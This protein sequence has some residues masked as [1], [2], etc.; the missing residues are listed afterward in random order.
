MVLYQRMLVRFLCVDIQSNSTTPGRVALACMFKE[1]GLRSP[2]TQLTKVQTEIS[3]RGWRTEASNL[4]AFNQEE[5]KRFPV[6]QIRG[7]CIIQSTGIAATHEPCVHVCTAKG[8]AIGIA[9][10]GSPWSCWYSCRLNDPAFDLDEQRLKSVHA[11][12]YQSRPIW[13]PKIT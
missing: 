9:S 10:I 5:A 4:C 13:L 3:V 7:D 11:I 2:R 12:V 1:A 6:P 8:R